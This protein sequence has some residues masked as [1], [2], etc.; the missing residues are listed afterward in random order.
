MADGR[1]IAHGEIVG[2]SGVRAAREAGDII[3]R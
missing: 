2:D 1:P 3:R